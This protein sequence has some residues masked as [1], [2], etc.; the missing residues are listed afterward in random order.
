MI[1][2]VQTN[3]LRETPEM[4]LKKH[5]AFSVLWK[6]PFFATIQ[7]RD[8]RIEAHQPTRVLCQI[9]GE[10]IHIPCCITGHRV[11]PSKTRVEWPHALPCSMLNWTDRTGWWQLRTSLIA[12]WRQQCE[13]AA[14]ASS[15]LT[16]ITLQLKSLRTHGNR[17]L[18]K[19]TWTDWNIFFIWERMMYLIRVRGGGNEFHR[20]TPGPEV[21]LCTQSKYL[22]MLWLYAITS[23]CTKSFWWAVWKHPFHSDP[24][25]SCMT[26]YRHRVLLQVTSICWRRG[27]TFGLPAGRSALPRQSNMLATSP[28]VSDTVCV[29]QSELNSSALCVCDPCWPQRVGEPQSIMRIIMMI[30]YVLKHSRKK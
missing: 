24:H 23:K 25:S 30:P 5:N 6:W 19:V 10:Q 27:G 7:R 28:P 15:R 16:F 17:W 21:Y 20:K 22:P 9:E 29:G 13:F 18:P 11:S 12:K 1:I 3:R 26:N 14:H 4:G 8:I 2:P